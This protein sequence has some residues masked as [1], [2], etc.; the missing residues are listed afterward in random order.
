MNFSFSDR[1]SPTYAIK[2]QTEQ[3]LFD[4]AIQHATKEKERERIAVTLSINL[5]ELSSANLTTPGNET[6]FL[7][8][9]LA[10]METAFGPPN[11]LPLCPELDGIKD[12]AGHMGQASLLI[13]DVSEDEIAAFHPE[14]EGGGHWEPKECRARHKHGEDLFNKGRIMNAA[15]RLA[16]KLNVDC[17][18]FHDVD[19]FPQDDRTPY[20]CPPTPRHI[21]A[22]VNSLAYQLW[23]K[24]IVG[25]ALAISM[26]D[27]L[28]VNGYSNMYWAWGGE[29][30][31]FGKRILSNN[32]TIER[33]DQTYKLLDSSGTRWVTDGVNETGRWTVMSV[34]VK[35]LYYHMMVDVGTPPPEWRS[36]S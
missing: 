21:G 26:H 29:D 9:D 4:E 20:S 15:F 22:F 7:E 27:Y 16:Q 24:E 8:Q 10:R 12:Y 25:G 35:P 23:Y 32:Y 28:A 33:P 34:K 18:V 2:R 13:E 1:S 19:M 11:S 30:D 6:D 31:D 5:E 36:G 17:V 3:S 14:V